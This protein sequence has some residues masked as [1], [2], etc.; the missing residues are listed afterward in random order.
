[1]YSFAGGIGKVVTCP[2]AFTPPT[3]LSLRGVKAVNKTNQT[4]RHVMKKHILFGT[5]ALLASSLLI[6]N[7]AHKD[8]VTAAAKKLAD[9]DNYAWKQ[10]DRKSTRL[11][12]SHL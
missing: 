5:M 4:Q 11:N 7:A 9:K 12:S 10:T 2:T 6:A 8:D 1:M 3:N